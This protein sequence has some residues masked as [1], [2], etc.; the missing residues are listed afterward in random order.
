MPRE[1]H[2]NLRKVILQKIESDPAFKQSLQNAQRRL[3]LFAELL[4]EVGYDRSNSETKKACDELMELIRESYRSAGCD[5]EKA[6]F[7][8][9]QTL[10][11]WIQL[12]H[13]VEM[14][15]EVV[16]SGNFTVSETYELALAWVE[17]QRVKQKLQATSSTHSPGSGMPITEIIQRAEKH[18]KDHQGVYP[19]RN[20]LANIIGCAP[21]SITKAV[22]RSVYLKARAAEHDAKK[23]LGHRV[24]IKQN[25]NEIVAKP[26]FDEDERDAELD[27][28]AAEQNKEQLREERQYQASKRRRNKK[29]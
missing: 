17:R 22:D 11:D 29:N 2:S 23:R 24:Y 28:L 19:G 1:T 5:L 14:P 10:E 26:Q 27:R 25:I 9:P 7:D 8:S 21:A 15:F 6:G 12:A 20:K 3:Q 18:V 16:R 4:Q 13:I